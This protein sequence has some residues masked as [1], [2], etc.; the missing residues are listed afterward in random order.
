MVNKL[1]LLVVRAC[2]TFHECY[3]ENNRK[4]KRNKCQFDFISFEAN[5]STDQKYQYI[6]IFQT[7]LYRVQIQYENWPCSN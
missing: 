3:A 4:D 5:C 2:T 1:K 7:Y 6:F